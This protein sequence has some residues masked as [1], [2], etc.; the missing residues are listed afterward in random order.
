[1]NTGSMFFLIV[2]ADH[3]PTERGF[4]HEQPQRINPVIAFK[5]TKTSRILQ[6]LTPSKALDFRHPLAELVGAKEEPGCERGRPPS[7]YRMSLFRPQSPR[8][9][10]SDPSAPPIFLVSEVDCSFVK[11]YKFNISERQVEPCKEPNK[12]RKICGVSLK[13]T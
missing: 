2:S 11:P 13:P 3:H 1:M 6:V 7:M 8:R 9:G 10:P 4:V 5:I 12:K